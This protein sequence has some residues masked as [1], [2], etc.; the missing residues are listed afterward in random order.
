MQISELLLHWVCFLN[1]HSIWLN[2]EQTKL[3]LQG[4]LKTN[5]PNKKSVPVLLAACSAPCSPCP[6]SSCPTA[7]TCWLLP[8][9]AC[10][11]AVLASL[12][13]GLWLCR[14]TDR[15]TVL[16]V[17]S[18]QL[19]C[20]Q[21]DACCKKL[22]HLGLCWNGNR[23]P[24]MTRDRYQHLGVGYKPFFHICNT[25]LLGLLC[26]LLCRQFRHPEGMLAFVKTIRRAGL[27]FCPQDPILCLSFAHWFVSAP[28]L[29]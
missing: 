6:I 20:L 27:H 18:S 13:H 1:V 10:A 25:A 28:F 14:R 4:D 11:R 19:G 23:D 15:R 2:Q 8:C 3:K 12:L 22:R 24:G 9:S 7:S 26:P 17:S 16:G 5:V 21:G 29:T